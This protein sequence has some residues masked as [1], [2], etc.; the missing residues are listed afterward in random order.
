MPAVLLETLFISNPKEE[1]KLKDPA[2]RARI[3]T[4][5]RSVDSTSARTFRRSIRSVLSSPC[6]SCGP[7]QPKPALLT[8]WSRRPA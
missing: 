8:S 5:K 3:G 7:Y 1:T 6:S 4:R 2:F